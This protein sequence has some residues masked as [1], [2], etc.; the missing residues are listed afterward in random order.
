MI[1]RGPGRE[2]PFRIVPYA[3]QTLDSPNPLVRFAHRRRLALSLRLAD[4][5]LPQGGVLVDFGAGE[6]GFVSALAAQRSDARCL[7]VEPH[8][9]LADPAVGTLDRLAD[10]TTGSVDLV[11][12]L[13]V[14]E[15]LSTAELQDFL[16]ACHR[17]LRPEGRV[18]VTV[19]IMYGLALPFKE[20]SRAIMRRRLDSI[21]PR[22]LLRAT[23]GLPIAR[24]PNLL[25]SHK[26]FDFRILRGAL[27]ATFTVQRETCSP[28]PV[29]PWWC[30]SQAVLIAGRTV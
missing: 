4:S 18:L 30:N 19:P 26:G 23:A 25:G 11:T 6:G 28:F 15:H 7:A 5:L 1:G 22:E 13:E 29:L 8:M 16:A 3:R 21:S 10:A 9:D 17:V 12:A 2:R 24:S 14:L 20:A 27:A